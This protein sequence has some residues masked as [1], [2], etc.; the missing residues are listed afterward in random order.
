VLAGKN[1]LAPDIF[2]HLFQL[3]L[4]DDGLIDQMLEIQVVGVKQL[5]LDV[6]IESLEKHVLLLL[7]RVDIVGSI[8]CQ[9]NELIHVFIHYHTPLVQVGKFLL[10]ELERATWYIVS[11]EMCLELILVDSLDIWVG[12]A[13]GL[14]L[15]CGSSK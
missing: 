11:S 13:V 8:P 14:P 5:K 9:L 10:L 15:V 2:L 1:Y 3:V 7:T 6:V 12:V 4:N